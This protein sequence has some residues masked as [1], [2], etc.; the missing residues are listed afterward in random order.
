MLNKYLFNELMK[1]SVLTSMHLITEKECA[2]IIASGPCMS[3][4]FVKMAFVSLWWYNEC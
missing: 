2:T 3:C 1:N 4:V